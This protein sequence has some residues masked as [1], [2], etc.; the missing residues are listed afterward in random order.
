MAMR[1][2][3]AST[4]SNR[5]S[6]I[7]EVPRVPRES[8]PEPDPSTF[9]PT[10]AIGADEAA[11]QIAQTTLRPDDTPME[12]EPRAMTAPGGA[13]PLHVPPELADSFAALGASLAS[14]VGKRIEENN[15]DASRGAAQ[16]LALITRFAPATEITTLCIKVPMKIRWKGHEKKEESLAFMHL[17]ASPESA[18]SGRLKTREGDPLHVMK[19]IGWV[20]NRD[21]IELCYK[22]F[23]EPHDIFVIAGGRELKRLQLELRSAGAHEKGS[24]AVCELNKMSAD[25]AIVSKLMNKLYLFPLGTKVREAIQQYS[26]ELTAAASAAKSALQLTATSDALI[27][28]VEHKRLYDQA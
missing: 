27:G 18:S 26:S 10:Y 5:R 21:Q 17:V 22:K 14:E 6:N 11:R 15:D 9:A 16:Q 3:K 8:D 1:A 28:L 7:K 12:P 2:L 13:E 25:G 19:V 20:D 23:L 4:S 24:V